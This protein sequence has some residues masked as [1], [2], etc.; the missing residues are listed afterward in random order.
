MCELPAPRDTSPPPF[1]YDADAADPVDVELLRELVALNRAVQAR[2]NVRRVA[3]GRYVLEGC[4]V[5]IGLR[6]SRQLVVRP[7]RSVD[8]ERSRSHYPSDDEGDE[9]SMEDGD[10]PDGACSEFEEVPLGTYLRQ[11]ANVGPDP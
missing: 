5:S 4:P 2:L 10:E 1:F 7:L 8:D 9:D 3:P 11:L 6:G